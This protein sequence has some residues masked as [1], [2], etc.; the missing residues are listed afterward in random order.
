MGKG[1]DHRWDAIESAAA[2]ARLIVYPVYP[3]LLVAGAVSLFSG[4]LATFVCGIILM[5]GGLR[6]TMRLRR[7][8]SLDLQLAHTLPCPHC[9]RRVSASA[10][11]CPR[12]ETKL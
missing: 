3:L 8:R 9:G 10:T 12:C 4:N 5:L 1:D 11:V 2:E 6:G 7:H